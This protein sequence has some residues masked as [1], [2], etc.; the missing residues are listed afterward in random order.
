M[1]T[2][3]ARSLAAVITK[4]SIVAG[5]VAG[6]VAMAG[7]A[8]ATAPP[9]G[10]PNPL[11]EFIPD[12]AGGRIWSA[13]DQSDGQ[14]Q[15]TINAQPSSLTDPGD[16]LL[17]VFVDGAG[18]H[19]VEYRND[20]LN[21]GKVWS[22]Y[23]LTDNAANSAFVAGSPTS[24]VDQ[25]SNTVHVYIQAP[26]GDLLEYVQNSPGG[27]TWGAWD[28]T[29]AAH[30]GMPIIGS[31][32]AAYN[33]GDGQVHIYAEGTNGH[34]LEF[35][36]DHVGGYLWNA[37]DL[38]AAAGNDAAV[39]GAPNAVVDPTTGLIHIYDTS[40]RGDL[41]EYVN[42]HVGG[43]LW[44]AWDLT[45][46]AGNGATVVGNPDAVVDQGSGLLHIYS[47]GHNGD[48]IEFVNDR[49]GGR[50]WSA[51]DLT[52][53]SGPGPVL[54][55][56]P[57]A[58]FDPADGRIH[59]YARLPND[60][61]V[62]YNNADVGGRLW[63]AWDV[64]VAAHG[65]TVGDDPDPVFWRDA[66]HVYVQDPPS[67]SVRDQ[68]VKTA[69]GQGQFGAAV[70]ETPF[71]S[72]CNPYTAFWGRGSATGCAPGTA[73]EE[74]CSDFAQWVW[75]VNG[76]DTSGINGLATSF[77]GWGQR[78]GTFKPGA[79]NDP[80]PGDAVV[81]GDLAHGV[82]THVAIVVGVSQGMI[83][84]VN[85]NGPSLVYEGGYFDPATSTIRGTGIIG[86]VS[87]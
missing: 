10:S 21:P 86:Y 62:E 81:W 7:P 12:H 5:L 3:P 11:I 77:I 57:R 18:R 44:S 69:Q 31:P 38:T 14:D 41:V 24:I 6:G 29:A 82:S 84:V 32:S 61:L 45:G 70:A 49:Y 36:N 87:P 52:A 4:A 78:H 51:W 9:P 71:G 65:P 60:D 39:A 55:G 37:W 67:P 40:Q 17:D 59:V 64:T 42:D 47:T 48:L 30:G 33:A 13:Y 63:N 50:L 23:D 56:D 16:G 27:S 1:R 74:W 8:G 72:G 68:I 34:L 58:V 35:V 28:L 15:P 26:S 54:A 83:G 22:S 46:A 80:Q 25:L 85:G 20:Q 53:A 66:V 2:S 79:T 73:S 19:L 75:Q 43:R 76:V